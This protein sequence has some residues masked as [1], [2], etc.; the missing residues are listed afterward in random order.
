MTKDY[1]YQKK[2]HKPLFE[3]IPEMMLS[4]NIVYNIVKEKMIYGLIKALSNM[5]NKP[6]V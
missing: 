2:L 5:Y 6:S 4:K 3:E 1:L